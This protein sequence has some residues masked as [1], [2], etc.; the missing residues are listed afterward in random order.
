MPPTPVSGGMPSRQRTSS[1][2]NTMRPPATST[3]TR[4]PPAASTIDPVTRASALV[5]P[6]PLTCRSVQSRM[7]GAML[8]GHQRSSARVGRRSS[9]TFRSARPPR[10][11][12]VADTDAGSRSKCSSSIATSPPV[13]RAAKLRFFA[14]QVVAEA[15]SS[16]TISPSRTRRRGIA[17]TPRPAAAGL[18][19]SSV[20]ASTRVVSAAA[21]SPIPA[22]RRPSAAR[23]TR[24]R[25]RDELDGP[26]SDRAEQQ[27]PGRD[28]HGELRQSGLRRAAGPEDAQV[29]HPHV[30]ITV[31]RI[32]LERRRADVDAG[33]AV[34]GGQGRFELRSEE[35]ELDGAARYPPGHARRDEQPS[36]QQPQ[37][38]RRHHP[39][40]VLHQ[41]GRILPGRT[42]EVSPPW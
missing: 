11:V 13:R 32:P 10:S 42:T 37:G 14:V 9:T 1:R 12:P 2:P 20:L 31:R 16:T 21:P 4:G 22:S 34:G 28:A 33:R 38:Q 24:M 5:T 17:P 8:V 30:E 6:P 39:H 18:E 40:H 27:R 36:D 35:V 29:V 41:R 25:G 15:W 26:G 3:A 23:T 7:D 19:P